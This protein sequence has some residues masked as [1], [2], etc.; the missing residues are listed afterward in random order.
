MKIGHFHCK[1]KAKGTCSITFPAS[2]A[3]GKHKGTV[4][5]PHYG[6]APIVVRVR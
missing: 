5:K 2:Y 3:Q 6:R 4:T 1:T